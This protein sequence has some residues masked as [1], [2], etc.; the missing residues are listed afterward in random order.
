ME[1]DERPTAP[2]SFVVEIDAVDLGELAGAF[3]VCGP[4]H[5]H[6]PCANEKSA[7]EDRDCPGARNSSVRR[8]VAPPSCLLFKPEPTAA[9]RQVRRWLPILSPGR[10]PTFRC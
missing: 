4:G 6:A 10:W 5:S 9:M 7:A 1:Q 3:R 2:V 8:E